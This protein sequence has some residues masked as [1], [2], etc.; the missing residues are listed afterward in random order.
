MIFFFQDFSKVDFKKSC[1]DKKI[2]RRD[3]IAHLRP[4]TCVDDVLACDL[5]IF[6]FLALVAMLFSQAEPSDQLVEG[7]MRTISVKLF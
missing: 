2:H 6:L 5:K 7:N 3:W 4:G 1:L